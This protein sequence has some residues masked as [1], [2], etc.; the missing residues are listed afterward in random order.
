MLFFSYRSEQLKLS[1]ALFGKAQYL[2]MRFNF[3]SALEVLNEAVASY[4]GF[5]PALVE[6]MKLQLA[7]QDWEQ[8]MET[9]QR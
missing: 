4:E 1:D 5:I 8:A 3:S 9:A 6:K 7:L 2:S